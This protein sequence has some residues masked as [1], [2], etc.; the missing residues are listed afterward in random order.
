MGQIEI[1]WNKRFPN[2]TIDLEINLSCNKKGAD[3]GQNEIP[4]NRILIK[5]TRDNSAQNDLL[6]KRHSLIFK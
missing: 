6:T 4:K 3:N 5:W 2:R 1:K